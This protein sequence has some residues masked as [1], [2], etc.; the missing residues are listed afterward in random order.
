[1]FINYDIKIYMLI[2]SYFIF[3]MIDVKIY[4]LI[5]SDRIFFIILQIISVVDLRRL[6]VY[7]LTIYEYSTF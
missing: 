6:Q 4:V 3:I 1:M 5:I 2:I 7:V